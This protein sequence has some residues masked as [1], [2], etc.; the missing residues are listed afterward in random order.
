ML[1]RTLLRE[2][3]SSRLHSRSAKYSRERHNQHAGTGPTSCGRASKRA[4]RPSRDAIPRE[5]V[6]RATE[7]VSARRLGGRDAH[8]PRRDSEETRGSKEGPTS[9]A[10]HQPPAKAGEGKG[11]QRENS[12][13]SDRPDGAGDRIA[14]SPPSVSRAS[15]GSGGGP[16]GPTARIGNVHRH[17]AMADRPVETTSPESPDR[18]SSAATCRL[19]G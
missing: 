4:A 14:R 9:A 10:G 1:S 5:W 19:V 15:P 18:V 13:R 11:R 7:S 2:A 12:N 8:R 17:R 6:A 16:V 3:K